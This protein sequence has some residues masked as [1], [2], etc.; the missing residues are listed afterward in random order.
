MFMR[1]RRLGSSSGSVRFRRGSAREEAKGHAP[2]TCVRGVEPRYAR[3]L[4]VAGQLHA[5]VRPGLRAD[6]HLGRRRKHNPHGGGNPY[7]LEIALD[8]DMLI[9]SVGWANSYYGEGNRLR[10]RVGR[11]LASVRVHRPPSARALHGTRVTRSPTRRR[12][13]YRPPDP[14]GPSCTDDA[15]RLVPTTEPITGSS[16]STVTTIFETAWALR[17]LER[18][19]MD[20]IDDPDLA[21][22]ILEIPYRYHL[23]P[24][25]RWRDGRGHDLAWRRRRHQ[26]GMMI[27]PRHWRRFLK[28]RMAD[29]IAE[30][31]AINPNV[32]V[33]YHTDG[34]V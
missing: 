5:R 28:P 8:E 34:C 2:R 33:A 1:L 13:G 14:N 15:E 12:R 4:P 18:L 27:S 31:K 17:G 23:R 20:F 16:E 29:F 19:M 6:M 9:T 30:L 21:E 32:K 26:Q 7:E 22:A 11:G 10:R 25:R 24:P 3:P